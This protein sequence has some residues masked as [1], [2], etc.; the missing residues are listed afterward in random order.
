MTRRE[1]D[2]EAMNPGS[3]LAGAGMGPLMRLSQVIRSTLVAAHIEPLGWS[4][5]TDAVN[6]ALMHA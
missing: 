4:T 1:S 6:Q 5:L 2:A 3:T